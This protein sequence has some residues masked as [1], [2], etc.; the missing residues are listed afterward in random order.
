[1]AYPKKYIAAKS[2]TLSIRWFSW[3]SVPYPPAPRYRSEQEG[4]CYRCRN[5]N[6]CT[7]RKAGAARE[8]RE[9]VE[10]LHLSVGWKKADPSLRPPAAG[11]LGMT[12]RCRAYE[13]EMSDNQIIAKKCVPMFIGT[14][15]PSTQIAFNAA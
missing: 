9:K 3:Q 10:S 7:L 15:F 13:A 4:G 2:R 5:K 8:K 11:R 1:V 12:K 6:P 14:H